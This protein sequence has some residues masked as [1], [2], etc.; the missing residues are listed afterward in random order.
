MEADA[1]TAQFRDEASRARAAKEADNAQVGAREWLQGVIVAAL[2]RDLCRLRDECAA[3]E[4][5]LA[6]S[7][8]KEQRL[9]VSQ[10]MPRRLC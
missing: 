3:Y 6:S 8:A 9:Q 1:Q 7:E 4:R 5:K 2:Q 10:P